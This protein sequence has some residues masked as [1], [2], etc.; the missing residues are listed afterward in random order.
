MKKKFA[1]LLAV[2]LVLTMGLG[3]VIWSNCAV[4][5]SRYTVT[6]PEIPAAFQGYRIVQVSDLH[7]DQFGQGNSRLLDAIRELQPDVIFLTGDLVDYYHTDVAVSE[8]FIRDVAQ[9]APTL[10]VMGNHEA[11]VGES[12][13]LEAQAKNAGVRVL[14]NETVTLEKAGETITVL[15]LQ[16]PAFAPPTLRPDH[17]E[18]ILEEALQSLEFGE[19][20]NILLSHRPN[21]LPLYARYEIDL[22]FGGHLHGGQFRLPF[23]GGLYAPSA[24]ALPKYDAGLWT[25]GDTTLIVSRGL[26]NSAFPFRV[27]NPPELVCVDL[28]CS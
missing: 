11:R 18:V 5:V 26:G 3:W 10:Y 4:T 14:K 7:N 22:A 17:D 28:A 1:C 6:D 19:G 9:I 15:G 12:V 13:L 8:D 16:D 20:Y 2:V 23:V 21:F 24:G 27:N 25:E